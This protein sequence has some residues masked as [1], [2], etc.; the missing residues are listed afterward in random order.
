MKRIYLN[1]STLNRPFDDQ[2]Q[3]R[4]KLETEALFQILSDIDSR[5]SKLILSEVTE[6]ENS[7]NPYYSIKIRIDELISKADRKIKVNAATKRQAKIF[8]NTGL[9]GMDALHLAAAV[10]GK[11]DFFVTCDDSFL[12]KAKKITTGQ[13][14]KIMNPIEYVLAEGL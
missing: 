3:A 1:N 5:N 12:K 13:S 2:I 11:V 8:E 4:I 7:K 14:I 9:N 6:L 10:Q